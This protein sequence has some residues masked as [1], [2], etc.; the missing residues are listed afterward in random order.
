MQRFG[1]IIKIKEEKK[2][3]YIKLHK[4]PPKEVLAMIKACNL[5]NYSIFIYEDFLFAYFEYTGSDFDADML[6][7]AKDEATQKWWSKT[8]P[9]Q[10]SLGYAGQKW[11]DIKSVFF[12]E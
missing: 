11:I 10:E 3:E 7:M 6:K 8:D 12:L 2:Q 5:Q 9:C 4:N 1:Q